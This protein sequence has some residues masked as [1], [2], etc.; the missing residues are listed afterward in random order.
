M[1]SLVHKFKIF[2][3]YLDHDDNLSG[4][5][6][7]DIV[8]NPVCSLPKVISPLKNHN[9]DDNQGDRFDDEAQAVADAYQVGA[10]DD[11]GDLEDASEED[12]DEVAA[13]DEDLFEF[14]DVDKGQKNDDKG[15]QK[16]NSDNAES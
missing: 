7:D 2:V 9:V 4:L 16:I 14:V 3:L 15:K 8:A 1:S 13:D 11:Q 10:D 12:P 6:W 5:Q